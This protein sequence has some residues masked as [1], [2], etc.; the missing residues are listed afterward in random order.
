[1]TRTKGQQRQVTEAEYSKQLDRSIASFR[2]GRVRDL[3]EVLD[4]LRAKH[5]G[6]TKDRPPPPNRPGTGKK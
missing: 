3:D 5:F 2:A 4:E 1:M 6:Q